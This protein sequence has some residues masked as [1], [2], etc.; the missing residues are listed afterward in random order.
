MR[1]LTNRCRTWIGLTIATLLLFPF[2]CAASGQA[3]QMSIPIQGAG[4]AFYFDEDNGRVIFPD[5]NVT[6][7]YAMDTTW[8]I[9]GV[10]TIDFQRLFDCLQEAHAEVPPN[11]WEMTGSNPDA[12]PEPHKYD[13][14]RKFEPAGLILWLQDAVDPNYIARIR[15]FPSN[16]V[17][18]PDDGHFVYIDFFVWKGEWSW[19]NETIQ[20]EYNLASEELWDIVVEIAGGKDQEISQISQTTGIARYATTGDAP[21]DLREITKYI[22][23]QDIIDGMVQCILNGESMGE[24]RMETDEP[25]HF[26]FFLEGGETMDLYLGVASLWNGEQWIY[27][28]MGRSFYRLDRDTIIEAVQNADIHTNGS[29]DLFNAY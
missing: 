16:V 12:L 21:S 27:A 25:H 22:A 11:Y 28:R 14:Y 19:E 15:L 6:A 10:E 5:Y 1:K 20:V 17:D 24:H 29:I 23:D 2:A 26:R 3:P 7:A 13:L 18:H 8:D 9:E 4:D